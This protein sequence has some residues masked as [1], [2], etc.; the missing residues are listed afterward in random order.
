MIPVSRILLEEEVPS[1][2]SQEQWRWDRFFFDNWFYFLIAA[3]IL[4]GIFMH[5]VILEFLVRKELMS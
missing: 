5:G 3:A 2:L 4:V 1:F